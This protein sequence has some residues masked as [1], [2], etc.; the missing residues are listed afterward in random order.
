MDKYIL[1][2]LIFVSS[3][4]LYTSTARAEE[5]MLPAEG[6]SSDV[7]TAFSAKIKDSEIH[8]VWKI[9]N[10]R[11]ISY[12]IV[13]RRDSEHGIFEPL[14]AD[15]R[16]RRSDYIEKST[17]ENNLRALKFSYTDEPES[18][19]VFYYRVKGYSG[20]G[21]LVFESD[22]IKI[23]ISGIRDF[24]L[25][26]NQPNP[27]NPVTT[28]KYELFSDTYVTIK[29]FDLIGR[30]I[31]TLADQFHT[32]GKYSVQFDASLHSNLTSGIYFYKLQ[33]DQYSDVK[34]MILS[35]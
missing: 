33:T 18:D 24:I 13:E 35:K 32:K 6:D 15:D 25:E 22:E 3:F 4:L 21:T 16:V 17:G 12:F 34:K 30:E 26:Q 11:N 7:L 1:P 23:G 9:S 10:L 27:F 31:S 28:I 5:M 19:G 20:S 29:V 14:N 8:L 2:L